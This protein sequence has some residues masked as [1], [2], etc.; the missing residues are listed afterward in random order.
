MKDI[1]DLIK[2]KEKLIRF[3]IETS[4]KSTQMA[5]GLRKMSE[6]NR[7]DS[8]KIEKLCETV[9]N[10]AIQIKHLSVICLMYVQASS[11]DSDVSQA[12]VKM[13]RGEEALLEMMRR[14]M[15][16]K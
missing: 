3:L 7:E 9:A 1:F 13:G 5:G 16:G 4:S 2:E 14:K 8:F 10:Q 11:F 6:S 15:N 12:M